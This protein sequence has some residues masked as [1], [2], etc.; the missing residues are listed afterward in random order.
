MRVDIENYV[1]TQKATSTILTFLSTE[2]V[3]GFTFELGAGIIIAVKKRTQNAENAKRRNEL[4]AANVKG[5]W[6]VC[7]DDG[8][9]ISVTEKTFSFSTQKY[10]IHII[11]QVEVENNYSI[12]VFEFGGNLR[13]QACTFSRTLAIILKQG[14]SNKKL[15]A[16]DTAVQMLV[17]IEL[18]FT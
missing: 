17:D 4:N 9:L 16:R 3:A 14:N 8:S 1:S 5:S 11:A 10:I 13:M 6:Y 7:S 15:L 18:L 12:I 2:C